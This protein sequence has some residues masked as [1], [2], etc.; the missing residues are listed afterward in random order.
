MEEKSKKK[1]DR[2]TWPV[3]GGMLFGL[4][5]GLLLVRQNPMALIGSLLAGMG[6]GIII[7]S[8]LSSEKRDES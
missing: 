7:S 6:A 3:A 5:I 8:F 1:N 2:S 4:G